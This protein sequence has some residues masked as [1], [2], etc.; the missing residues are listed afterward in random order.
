MVCP[1][2]LAHIGRLISSLTAQYS[3]ELPFAFL[4]L[5]LFLFVV[6][7][8]KRPKR[9]KLNMVLNNWV[10]PFRLPWWCR[11]LPVDSRAV[12]HR[13][14]Q[15]ACFSRPSVRPTGR[16]IE[17]TSKLLRVCHMVCMTHAVAGATREAGNMM[18]KTLAGV[19]WWR[20][21]GHARS[22]VPDRK[23]KGCTNS[24]LSVQHNRLPS[25]E[26]HVYYFLQCSSGKST[27]IFL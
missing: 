16:A 21:R 3:L 7:P 8:L 23:R 13:P 17:A 20:A 15:G 11:Y 24:P 5:D 6:L 26:Q 14:A 4:M 10:R 18:G 22:A 9:L 2:S 25:H 12:R 1:C 19:Q 27:S